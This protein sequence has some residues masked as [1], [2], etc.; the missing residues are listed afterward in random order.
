VAALDRPAVVAVDG[1]FAQRPELVDAWDLVIYVHA[2]DV[3]RVARMSVRDGVPDDPAYPDQ[4]RYLDAQRFYRDRCAPLDRAQ[5]VVDN[6]DPGHP[7][8]I[9]R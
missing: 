2:D 6:T 5:L 4:R 7:H 9:P 1:V 3:V 8:L